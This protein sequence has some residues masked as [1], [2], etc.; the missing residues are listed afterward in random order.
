MALSHRANCVLPKCGDLVRHREAEV[1]LESGP[2][3][4][5]SAVAAVDECRFLLDDGFIGYRATWE[6]L[7]TFD[8]ETKQNIN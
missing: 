4:W 7:W 2:W 3:Q 8:D 6:I 1:A 5:V